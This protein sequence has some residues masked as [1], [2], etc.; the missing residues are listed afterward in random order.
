LSDKDIGVEPPPPPLRAA[1][2]ALA[3]QSLP[4]KGACWY[5]D[6]PVDSVRRFCGKEC[7]DGFDEEAAFTR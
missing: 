2:P 7:A 6:K 5:C 4:A 3:R 1:T